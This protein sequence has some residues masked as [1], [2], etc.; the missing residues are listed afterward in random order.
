MK[1]ALAIV[2]LLGMVSVEEVTA[3]TRQAPVGVTFV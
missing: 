2:A 1:Y 3:I